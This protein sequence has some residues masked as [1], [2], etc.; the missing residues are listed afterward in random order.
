MRIINLDTWPRRK[1]FALFN[2]FDYPH[3]NLCANVDVTQ[4]RA[5]VRAREVN[6]T[7][8]TIYLLARVAN[9]IPSFRY[10]I[11][12]EQIV[13]HEAVHPSHTIA[14]AGDLFS[15]CTI[16]YDPDFAVFAPRAADTIAYRQE[17]PTLE[18]APGQD[19]LLYLSAIPWISFTGLLHPI[20]MHPVDSVPRI[21]WG[22]FSP[23][24]DRW[25]MPLSVQVHH[26]LLDGFHVGQYFEQV[27][28][29]LGQPEQL[30]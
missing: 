18:D 6:F 22:K 21:V 23:M 14:T 15:F 3:F 13:E 7:I 16:P 2:R 8:A 20:H 10:R 9:E 29:Y 12:G 11:R 19:D 1:Q 27:Q 24:N 30:L 26:A 5:A 25:Q 17:N 28:T 4:F